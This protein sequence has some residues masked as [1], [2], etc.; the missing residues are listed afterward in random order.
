M[1]KSQ[2]KINSRRDALLFL[3]IY[4]PRL[5]SKNRWQRLSAGLRGP[6]KQ[7]AGDDKWLVISQSEATAQRLGFSGEMWGYCISSGTSSN[8][9]VFAAS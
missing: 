7:E 8:N 1:V 2:K 9:S 5:L 6:C 4:S 3:G